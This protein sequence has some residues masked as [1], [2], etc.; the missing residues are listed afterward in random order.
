MSTLPP[1]KRAAVY[2]WFK[3]QGSSDAQA[4][5][6]ETLH[7]GKFDFVGDVLVLKETN[8]AADDPKSI[9]RM[10]ELAGHLFPPV[11]ETPLADRAFLG[12]GNKT[13]AAAL[14]KE[15]G[16]PEA[17]RIANKYGKATPWDTK[18]GTRPADAE[19]PAKQKGETN[20]WSDIPANVDPRTGKYLPAALNRQ[21]ALARASV[22]AATGIAAA[23]GAKLGD[24]RPPGRSRRVA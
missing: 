23:A 20:P 22:Q 11:Y 2:D 21:F 13:A 3:S 12:V 8:V 4:L 14:V 10:R 16:L 1:D 17:T 6:A 19:P 7:T 24:I 5:D 18:S 9:E 15:V